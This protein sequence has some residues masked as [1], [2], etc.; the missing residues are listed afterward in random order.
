M[1]RCRHDGKLGRGEITIGRL[2]ETWEPSNNYRCK[3]FFTGP[4]ALADTRPDCVQILYR[5]Y[6][7][8][9]ES[10][11]VC[12]TCIRLRSEL[13]CRFG[14]FWECPNGGEKCQYRHALPPG[15]VLKSQ[16]KAAEEAAKANT[17]SLE[18]FLEVEVRLMVS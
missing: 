10:A 1:P 12:R 6:R 14:W 16:K 2:I 7:E 9:K 4:R 8:S 3:S 5:G 18:E 15:F 11:F 17:I 13:V